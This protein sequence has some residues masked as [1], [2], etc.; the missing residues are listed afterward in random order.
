MYEQHASQLNDEQRS[1]WIDSYCDS[2]SPYSAQDQVYHAQLL[3]SS[4][5]APVETINSMGDW[6]NMGNTVRLP[7]SPDRRSGAG[8]ST[9]Y[10]H[11]TFECNNTQ[12]NDLLCSTS[13]GGYLTSG[14]QIAPETDFQQS[15]RFDLSHNACCY[16]TAYV[17]SGTHNLH[18]PF[19]HARSNRTWRGYTSM[20]D[21]LQHYSCCVHLL[22]IPAAKPRT[23]QTLLHPAYR[24]EC[25]DTGIFTKRGR[26]H[27]EYIWANGHY[28]RHCDHVAS[29]C[30][31]SNYTVLHEPVRILNCPQ[32]YHSSCAADEQLSQRESS[33]S[34]YPFENGCEQDTH[35]DASDL[36]AHEPTHRY[37]QPKDCSEATGCKPRQ[38][39]VSLDRKRRLNRGGPS[40]A[41]ISSTRYRSGS[42]Q[43]A[44]AAVRDN[45]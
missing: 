29:T 3:H 40:V 39:I 33:C 9:F 41:S 28:G 2:A 22:G 23:G 44:L 21:A 13:Y 42:A 4:S 43:E 31:H 38:N 19:Q 8:S 11:P 6:M 30:R 12:S 10:T 45:R 14:E 7:S 24:T 25:T 35:V 27:A 1:S 36:A 17:D 37:V 18:G 20:P 34:T 5:S 16:C 26:P 32:I 15:S